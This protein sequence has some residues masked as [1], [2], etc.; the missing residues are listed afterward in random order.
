MPTDLT[1][2]RPDIDLAASGLPTN[3]YAYTLPEVARR[4]HVSESSIRRW[5]R[6][7]DLPATRIGPGGRYRISAAAVASLEI[8]P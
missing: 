8:R 3:R 2:A 7:G 6:T 4:L 1:L 5:I